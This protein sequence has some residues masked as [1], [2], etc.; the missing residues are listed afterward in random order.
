MT[1]TQ[2]L[3][4]CLGS[5]KPLSPETCCT[6]LLLLLLLLACA[7]LRGGGGWEIIL[8]MGIRGPERTA[9]RGGASEA[10]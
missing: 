2:D 5:W 8:M 7:R 4:P 3:A 1:L 6:V 9:V 10:D